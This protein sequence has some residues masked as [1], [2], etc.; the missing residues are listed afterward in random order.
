MV[1]SLRLYNPESYSIAQAVDLAISAHRLE[2]TAAAVYRALWDLPQDDEGSVMIEPGPWSLALIRAGQDLLPDQIRKA[3]TRSLSQCGL[4]AYGHSV[5]RRPWRVWL[6]EMQQPAQGNLFD[7]LRDPRAGREDL[8]LH[9]PPTRPVQR[10]LFPHAEPCEAS[11]PRKNERHEQHEQ[12]E[13]SLAAAASS[14]AHAG[15]ERRPE[16]LAPSPG[17][18]G[19]EPATRPSSAP[20]PAAASL[21][22]SQPVSVLHGDPHIDVRSAPKSAPGPERSAPQPERSA[23]D[24]AA[25]ATREPGSLGETFRRRSQEVRRQAT[26]GKNIPREISAAE[27]FFGPLDPADPR[28]LRAAEDVARWTLKHRLDS[29]PKFAGWMTWFLALAVRVRGLPEAAAAEIL[30]AVE[31]ARARGDGHRWGIVFTLELRAQL[32]RLAI[33]W[34]ATQGMAAVLKRL[35]VP[36]DPRW[37][38]L[39]RRRL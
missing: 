34:R 37:S 23:P 11:E 30:A 29:D 19:P 35:D 36:W 2:P 26:E 5:P 31:R 10:E 13:T 14:S 24:T 32:E 20:G 39:E 16:P 28:V 8:R 17:I 1:A 18:A 9:A 6:L 12:H 25:G 3:I 33:P 7:E 4:V 22:V 15:V 21:P 38:Q 27:K